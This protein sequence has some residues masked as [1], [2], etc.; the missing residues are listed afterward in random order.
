MASSPGWRALPGISGRATSRARWSRRPL[1]RTR[2]SVSGFGGAHGTWRD[3]EDGWP[4]T[5]PVEQGSVYSTISFRAQLDPR[6][7][8]TVR[9]WVCAGHNLTEVTRLHQRVLKEG[10]ERL[11]TD[12]RKYWT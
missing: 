6:N 7:A 5:N 10:F 4:S 1:P 2:R 9:S 12:T 3:A 8:A 11:R